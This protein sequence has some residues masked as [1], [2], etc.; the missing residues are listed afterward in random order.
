MSDRYRFD[1]GQSRFTVQA[2]ATGHALGLRPQPDVRGP[3]LHGQSALRGRRDRGADAGPDRQGRL[4]RV[5]GPGQRRRPQGDRGAGC[6]GR[7]SRPRPIPRSRYQ[8]ADVPAEP[9]ARGRVPA[10]HRRPPVAARRDPAP[11]RSTAKLQVF[12]DGVRLTRR[13]P[14]AAVRLPDQAGDRP[15][16]DDQAEGRAADCLRPRS[17]CRRGH[18][19]A[20]HPRSPA[21]ATSSWA[22]TPSASRSPDAW[23]RASCRKA[24][25]SSISASGA[26]P[27][28]C[29]PRRLRGGHPGRRRSP[30]RAAR[31]ALRARADDGPGP[32]EWRTPAPWSRRTGWT[33]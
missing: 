3:R 19:A 5:A 14:A 21:S 1:P 10:P 30:R 33:R 32:S 15:G 20:S 28:L 26:R 27:D 9:I 7:S 16:R 24:C 11:A 12:E 18:D 6:G 8:A 2:F 22:T 17:P 25:A 29:A 31:H 4:A 13:L 23:R